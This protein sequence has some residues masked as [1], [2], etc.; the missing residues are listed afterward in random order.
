VILFRYLAKE[1]LISLFAV[2][3]TLLVIVMSGRFVKYLAQAAAGKLSPDILLNIM[4]YRLPS[5]LELVLPLSLFIAILLAYG[6]MYVESEMTVMAA[7]GLSDR[8]LA[9][10]TL[11]PSICV[12]VVVGYLS[13][14]ASPI[15]I[16]KVQEIFEDTQNSSGLELLIEGRFRVDE[17]SG[18]VTY[19]E[20]LDNDAGIMR[21]VFSAEQ[22]LGSEG[23][24]QLTVIFAEQGNIQMS[25]DQ[26]SRYLVLRNGYQSVG[27]PGGLRYRI[28][29]FDEYGQLVRD[30]AIQKTL[31]KRAD[32]RTTEQL[33]NSTRLEDKATLQWRIS[34]V[35]LVPVIALVAQALSRTSH[36]RGRYVKM[37]PAFIIY[38]TYLVALNAARDAIGKEKISPDLGMWWVHLVFL[39][40]GITLLFGG[41]WLRRFRAPIA[42]TPV[43]SLP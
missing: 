10:Y 14:Y 18:R 42:S 6:R 26:Q 16:G 20:F 21:D 28:S 43:A 3:A 29:Q 38:I 22:S 39:G 41:D 13:L 37:L 33:L 4:V 25:D 15:G 24:E 2:S 34:L 35:I 9:V 8:R 36:R 11:V 31:Y 32:A 23:E 1:I 40:L 30:P 17:Q 5:F 27:Q 12:A 7:C 19:V